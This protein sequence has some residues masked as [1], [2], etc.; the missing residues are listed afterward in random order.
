MP[1]KF[2]RH[3][4]TEV[5]YTSMLINNSYVRN[6]DDRV[7]R[8]DLPCCGENL[9]FSRRIKYLQVLIGV[10]HD[11]IL[12]KEYDFNASFFAFF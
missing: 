4:Q 8:Y 12:D 1:S 9:I 3:A 7:I 6:H 10:V 2:S 5:V 11:H